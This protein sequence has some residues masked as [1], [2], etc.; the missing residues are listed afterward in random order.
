[1]PNLIAFISFS[2]PKYLNPLLHLV[3]LYLGKPKSQGRKPHIVIDRSFF[4]IKIFLSDLS[5]FVAVINFSNR[6]LFTTRRV[7]ETRVGKVLIYEH[8]RPGNCSLVL[9]NGSCII[10]SRRISI[11]YI[12]HTCFVRREPN[13]YPSAS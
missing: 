5:K 13:R 6:Q 12:I 9:K 8:F 10:E 1:M 7:T 4:S 11:H 2:M 3:W